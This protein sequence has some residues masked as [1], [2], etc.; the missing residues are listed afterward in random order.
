MFQALK[1]KIGGQR[2]SVEV[3]E[4]DRYRWTV[5][6]VREGFAWAYRQNLERPY[7]SEYIR[8]EEEARRERRGL[9]RQGSRSRLGSLGKG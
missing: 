9:W 8:A 7:A 1:G 3:R 4:I 5:S 6:V 2:V